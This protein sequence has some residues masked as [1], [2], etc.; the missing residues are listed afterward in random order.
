MIVLFLPVKKW[1]TALQRIIIARL[2]TLRG[3][4]N[5]LDY[6]FPGPNTPLP[7]ERVNVVLGEADASL[8]PEM[9]QDAS[10]TPFVDGDRGDTQVLCDILWF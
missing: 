5:P 3:I 6:P 4:Q 7:D 1:S 9:G 8:E 2:L 10:L